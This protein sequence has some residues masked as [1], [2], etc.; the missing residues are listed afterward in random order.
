MFAI[1]LLSAILLSTY[2]LLIWRLGMKALHIVVAA[3]DDRFAGQLYFFFETESEAKK[4]E[5]DL[6]GGALK[7]ALARVRLVQETVYDSWEECKEHRSL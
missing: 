3:E 7:F 4:C 1:H 5:E 6:K 2:V